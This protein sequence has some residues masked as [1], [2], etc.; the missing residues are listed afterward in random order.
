MSMTFFLKAL[1]LSL[2]DLDAPNPKIIAPVRLQKTHNFHST[3]S[4]SRSP[5]PVTV[6]RQGPVKRPK[7]RLRRLRRRLG[8]RLGR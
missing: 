5:K 1:L 8:D 2:C 7:Q 6:R 3:P 4:S